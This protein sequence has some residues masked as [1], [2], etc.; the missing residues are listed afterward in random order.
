MSDNLQAAAT[1]VYRAAKRN[2]PEK[3]VV[4]RNTLDQVIKYGED[5]RLTTENLVA[6][7]FGA[8]AAL[9][10]QLIELRKPSDLVDS[11]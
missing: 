2:T 5:E 10:G 11:E 9:E 6:C 1:E 8:I 7:L 4:T 3:F